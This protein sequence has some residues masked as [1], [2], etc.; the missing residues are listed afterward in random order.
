MLLDCLMF[1]ALLALILGLALA[2]FY[3]VLDHSRNLSRNAARIAATLEA[4]ERWRE[5]VRSAIT[6]PRRLNEGGASVLHL[7]QATGEVRYAFR[8]GAVYRQ[9]LPNT[10]WLPVLS[11]VKDSRMVEDRRERV[12]SLRWEVELQPS[13]SRMKPMFTFQSVPRSQ[14]KP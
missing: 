3:S 4:G 10:N 1:I 12:I 9:A 13:K 6:A 5:D 11:D 2:A 8:D 7:P 14:P